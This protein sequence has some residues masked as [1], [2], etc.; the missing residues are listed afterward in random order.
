MISNTSY[1]SLVTPTD[2]QYTWPAKGHHQLQ[3]TP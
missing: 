1:L 3:H 2:T